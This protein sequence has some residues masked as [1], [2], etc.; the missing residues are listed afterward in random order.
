MNLFESSA[1]NHIAATV[2]RMSMG[3]RL[4][5][6]LDFRQRDAAS[7]I[8]A[9]QVSKGLVYNILNDVTKPDKIRAETALAV[10]RELGVRIEWLV[11]GKGPMA[12][13]GESH[14]LGI[15]PEILA[16]AMKLLSAT[17]AITN[18]SVSEDAAPYR[19]AL[20]YE[21]LQAE[22]GAVPESNVLDFTTRFARKLREGVTSGN[23]RRSDP[24]AGAEAGGS[25]ERKRAS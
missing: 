5:Q 13:A 7:L 24:G 23:Y 3:D 20:A 8:A 17:D 16:A 1:M 19:I 21:F 4:Q 22:G 9:L 11:Q 12:A 15:D 18:E 14:A 25:H 6:A 10:S 2:P